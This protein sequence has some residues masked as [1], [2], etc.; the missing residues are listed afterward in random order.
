MLQCVA[1]TE[2]LMP[3]RCVAVC[4]SVWQCVTMRCSEL[5]CVAACCSVLQ[6]VAVCCRVLQCVAVRGSELQVVAHTEGLMPLRLKSGTKSNSATGDS[7]C[8]RTISAGKKD[9]RKIDEMI[10]GHK[11]K[12]CNWRL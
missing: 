6:C 4:C 2:G 10:V 7:S 8:S 1:H 9:N 11:V 5:Q 12:F 3:L